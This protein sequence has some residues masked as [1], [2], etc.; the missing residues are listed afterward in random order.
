[1]SITIPLIR[2]FALFPALGWFARHGITEE[3]V[4]KSANLPPDLASFPF[5]PVPLVLVASMLCAAARQVGPDLPC[6][7]VFET[8]DLEIAMLGKVALGAGTPREALARIIPALPFYCSHE[9]VSMER[10]GGATIVREFFSYRF[11]AET[12]H[13]LLQ[14]AAAMV[15]RICGLDRASPE[16]FLRIELPPHPDFGLQHLI[17]WF[18]AGLVETRSHGFA[19]TVE[20]QIMDRRFNRMAR[21]RV[22]GRQ[23]PKQPTL[24]GDGSLSASVR[25]L[26][27]SMMECGQTLSIERLSA[28]AGAS[29]RT[30]QRQLRAEHTS[31]SELLAEIR[32]DEA[33]RRLYQ[34]N[35]TIASIAAQLGY[36]DQACLTRAFR[37]W[38]GSPPRHFRTQLSR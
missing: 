12:R 17:P 19:I 25:S 7:I 8:D 13:L 28:A 14:Y 24:R 27:V 29:V 1:M 35:A 36:S 32:H 20:D 10:K 2:G 31:Y 9:Q 6:R 15:H 30:F 38:T 5:R 16:R 4:L 18:G 21:S 33:Q 11:D 37:R 22:Q 3:E 34:T 26:L 23:L